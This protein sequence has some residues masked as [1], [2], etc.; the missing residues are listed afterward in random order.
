MKE[1]VVD[2]GGTHVKVLATGPKEP[3]ELAS[4]PALMAKQMVSEVR[5][6]AGKWRYDVVSIGYPGPVIRNRPIAEPHN[7]RCG[8]QKEMAAQCHRRGRAPDHCHRTR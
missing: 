7:L 3:C 2:I 8:W 4:G 6:A 1:L 5:K